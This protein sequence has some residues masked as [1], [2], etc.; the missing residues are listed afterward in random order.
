MMRFLRAVLVGS[1]VL[2]FATPAHANLI[3]Q[4]TFTTDTATGLDGLHL[5]ATRN[6]SY[7]DVTA[8]LGSTFSGY[9]YATADEVKTFFLDAGIAGTPQPC[10]PSP[11]CFYATDPNATVENFINLIG[12]SIFA[13]VYLADGVFGLTSTPYGPPSWPGCGPGCIAYVNAEVRTNTGFGEVV[14][15]GG[16]RDYISDPSYASWLVRPTQTSPVPAPPT[17]PLFATGL[18]LMAWLARRRT[19]SRNLTFDRSSGMQIRKNWRHSAG[20]MVFAT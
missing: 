1:L 15:G 12:G 13:P 20:G 10:T 9:R 6:L 5:T 2:S 7:L 17:L 14:I 11:A 4:G 3:D 16:L 8:Q 19:V 18:G